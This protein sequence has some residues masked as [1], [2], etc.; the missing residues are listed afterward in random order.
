MILEVV[1]V[2][3]WPPFRNVEISVEEQVLPLHP[4]AQRQDHEKSHLKVEQYP[5]M[6]HDSFPWNQYNRIG[7]DNDDS[8]CSRRHVLPF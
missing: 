8:N 5:Q 4:M 1:P 7:H 6:S 2:E 3:Q